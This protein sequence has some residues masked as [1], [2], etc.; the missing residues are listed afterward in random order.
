MHTSVIAGVKALPEDA[1][2]V[3]FF[4][5][6]QPLISPEVVVKVVEEWQNSGKGIVLPVH[7]GKRGHPALYDI[8]LRNEILNLDPSVGLRSVALKFQDE[9]MEV[10]TGCPGILK[11]ID[12]RE[13]YFQTK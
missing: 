1:K 6:D 10:A 13:E 7:K 8:R 2:A 9:I 3:A 5:G 4:L 12:T 11:D